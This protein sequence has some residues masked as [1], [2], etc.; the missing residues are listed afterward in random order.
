MKLAYKSSILVLAVLIAAAACKKTTPTEEPEEEAPV[1]TAPP[2]NM[3]E[4]FAQ[5][6]VQAQ[7]AVVNAANTQTIMI[8]GAK[9]EVPA[10]AF[11]TP[12]GGAVTGNISI[13]VKGIYTKSDVILSGAPANS[14]G[15]LIATKGCIKVTASQ[16]GQVLRMANTTT[17]HVNVPEKTA[18]TDPNLR[19]YYANKV[20]V[21]DSNLCWKAASDSSNIPVV[22]DASSSKYYYRAKLDSVNWLNTGRF[23]D[24]TCTK[25]S[26]T[27]TVGSSFNKTNTAIYISLNGAVIVGA[28]YEIGT[29]T[30]RISNIPVGKSVNIIGISTLNG[31]YYS[32]V[33]P[34]TV[35]SGMNLNLN[36]QSSSL[37]TIKAQL[38][39]LP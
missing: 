3:T 10:N 17:V 13:S 33:F 18:I 27:V 5:N 22:F 28:L 36:L 34:T 37:N 12:T 29:N 1:V 21:V 38:N 7:T 24:T 8:S 9:M 14:A 6:G 23:W 26:V 31:T 19:K 4:L 35:T 30:F 20:S 25:T 11:V 32:A 16:N 2:A 15:R 39:A